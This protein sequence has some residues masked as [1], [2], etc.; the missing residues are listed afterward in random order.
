MN[1]PHLRLF[2]APSIETTAR[3]AAAFSALGNLAPSGMA[4]NIAFIGS[5]S[6]DERVAAV[7]GLHGAG[8][9]PRPIISSRRLISP[10]VL[11]SYLIQSIEVGQVD[12]IFLVGGDP[13]T[14]AGPFTDSLQVIEGGYLEGLGLQSVGVAG[15]PEGHPM[16]ADEVLWRYLK[17]KTDALGSQ[18]FEVEI[19]TQLSFDA[20]AVV[21]WIRQ[22]RDAGIDAPIRIGIPAPATMAG[23]LNF[24]RQCRVGTSTQL[25]KHYG[26]QLTSLMNPQGPDRFL[27][28]LMEQMDPPELQTLRLHLFPIGNPMHVLQWLER[29]KRRHLEG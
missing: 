4:V 5:E 14:P 9:R 27:D 6:F 17:R 3:D 24:A 25:L 15:Y 28:T 13:A 11:R 21:S 26:W 22:V 20:Q 29:G 7:A 23:I 8:F 12:G 18:G 19:T 2:D 10:E 16:I 1:P